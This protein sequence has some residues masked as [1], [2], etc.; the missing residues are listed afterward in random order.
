[1]QSVA[2]NKVYLFFAGVLKQE[3]NMYIFCYFCVK[4]GIK[5]LNDRYTNCIH[6]LFNCFE[7]TNGSF[8]V[9]MFSFAWPLL[10]CNCYCQ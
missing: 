3:K 10:E 8:S 9:E 6:L 2:L 7:I 1:M 4:F 5:E